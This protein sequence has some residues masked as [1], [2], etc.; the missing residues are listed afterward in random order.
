MGLATS[1]ARRRTACANRRRGFPP[2]PSSFSGKTNGREGWARGAIVTS[3]L[4][5]KVPEDS[6]GSLWEDRVVL[7]EIFWKALRDHPVLC[8]SRHP[9]AARPLDELG[10]LCVARLALS[11]A[12]QAHSDLLA[13]CAYTVRRWLQ[14]HQALQ[15]KLPGGLG[16][17]HGRLSRGPSGGRRGWHY[18][19]PGPAACRSASGGRLT[20]HSYEGQKPGHSGLG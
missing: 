4:R 19:A 7:D 20:P 1:A 6:Q 12:R 13:G 2:A 16:R 15:T 11:P 8:W 3:G 14:S 18:P 5:F 17:C 10:H 9:A